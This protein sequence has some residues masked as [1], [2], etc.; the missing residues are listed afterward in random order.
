MTSFLGMLA[1]REPGV[2]VGP[3]ANFL[4][5]IYNI[6]FNFIHGFTQDGSLAIAIILF[7]L[8]V[9]VVLFPLS[10]HQQKSTFKMQK[11]Q[12]EMNKIRDKYAK[13]KDPES[14]QKMAIELQEFQKKNGI[15]LFGGCLPLLVQLPI[16]Y[17][18]FYLFQQAYI[19]VDVVNAN[20]QAITDVILNIP[21]EQRVDIFYDLA[22]SKRLAMDLAVN[23]DVMHLVSL[24]S[25]ADW[26]SV[27]SQAG[28]FANQLTPLFSQKMAIENFI[29]INLVTKPGLGFPGIIIPLLSAGST[30]LQSKLMTSGQ[31]KPD[32][33]DP[34]AASMK[35]M[36][37]MMPIMMGV[38]T[39]S[40]P[41]GLGL[42]WIVGNIFQIIQQFG[43]NKYFKAKDK[44]SEKNLQEI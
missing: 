25:E 7:T 22:M 30:F 18:L 20:Y 9:K 15:S 19:Y 8:L 10:F 37:Y 23:S 39:V 16:L 43:L 14:Q 41:A 40:M 3:I 32:G 6:L 26:N 5:S 12:P 31:P 35:M 27:I 33:N 44:H 1:V 17:A 38:M 2:I 11:L 34:M 21:V 36:T 42:Y 13:K 29:G 28:E 4:G 24:L